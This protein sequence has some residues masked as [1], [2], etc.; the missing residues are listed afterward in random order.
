MGP[1]SAQQ[2]LSVRDLR[3][4]WKP[5]K[6]RVS[7]NQRYQPI[8]IRF[9]RAC[10]WLQRAEALDN[11]DLDQRLILQWIAF[12]SLYGRWDLSR[13]EPEPD[14]R[15]I[16]EFLTRMLALDQQGRIAALMD[17]QRELILSIF[18]DDYLAD[19]FWEQGRPSSAMRHKATRWYADRNYA[20]LLSGLIDRIYPLRCQLVHGAATFNGKLNRSA[21]R[22]M[23]PRKALVESRCRNLAENIGFVLTLNVKRLYCIIIG[24]YHVLQHRGSAPKLRRSKA[25]VN[26]LF[27][28]TGCI[29]VFVRRELE[30]RV[31]ASGECRRDHR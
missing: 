11:A 5:F 17:D 2:V 20:L 23:S 18:S 25:S 30:A 24:P 31:R 14:T 28:C 6:E 1:H 7:K 29:S 12:N 8:C 21:T 3:R 9:H 22:R 16:S 27:F 19:Y 10:S 4:R 13:C 15:T 26:R